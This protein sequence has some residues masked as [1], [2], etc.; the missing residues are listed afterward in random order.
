MKQ[1]HVLLIDDDE[2]LSALL[3]EL[4]VSKGYHIDSV[5]TGEEGARKATAGAYDLVILDVM[6]PGIDGFDVLRKIRKQSGIPVVMLTAKGEDSDRIAGFEGGAD[7]YLSKPFNPRELLL[8]VRA[9]LR[10]GTKLETTDSDTLSV[11]PLRLYIKQLEARVGDRLIT[12]TGTE[13]RVL[14]ELMRSPGMV[15]TRESLTERALGRPRVAYDRA[16]DTHISH[17]RKKIGR[18]QLKRPVIRC[19]RGTGYLLVP[20]WQPEQS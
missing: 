7:D 15:Q 16:V 3:E 5:F 4:F 2:Q 9:I 20:D 1:P 8:R 11:G 10:R 12:L 13:E 17:L 6:L 19:I 14:E 18:D